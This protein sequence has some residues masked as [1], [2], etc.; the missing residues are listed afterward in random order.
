MEVKSLTFSVVK[1]HLTNERFHIGN[2]PIPTI[3]PIKSLVRWYNA[4]RR[5]TQGLEQLQ[6]DTVNGLKQ[7]NNTALPGK[8]KALVLSVWAATPTRVAK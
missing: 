6:R 4:D 3:L 2:E 1:G 7:I 8:L 5:N